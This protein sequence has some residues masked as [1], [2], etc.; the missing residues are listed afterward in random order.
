MLLFELA[1]DLYELLYTLQSVSIQTNKQEHDLL[2]FAQQ[3][4]K[5]K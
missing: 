5:A 3:A 1:S 2:W 4:W